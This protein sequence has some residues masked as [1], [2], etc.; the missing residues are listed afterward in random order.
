LHPHK[1]GEN[2]QKYKEIKKIQRKL[3][4]KQELGIYEVISKTRYEEE[5]EWY[6]QDD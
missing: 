1:S 2:I 4:M 6:L 3:W 5:Q